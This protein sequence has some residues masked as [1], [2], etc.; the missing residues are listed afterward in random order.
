MFSLLRKTISEFSDDNCTRMAAALAYYTAFS[1]APLM[2]LI[3]TISGF[4]WEPSDV[5]GLIESEIKSVV[6]DDGAAQVKTMLSSAT[7]SEGGVFASVAS[8]VMLLLGATGLVGQ[9]QSALNDTWSV[10]PDPEQGGVMNFIGKR[11][12]SLGMIC[13]IAFLLLVSF[14]LTSV[15]SAAGGRIANWLP[16]DVSQGLLVGLNFVV[17]LGVVTT[18]FAFMFKFLPDAKVSWSNGT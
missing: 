5:E 4:V 3:L 16:A 8:G 2:I 1:L 11:F 18:I 17:S 12:L 7:T 9:L 15:L 10:Q 14:V 13:A 6:G